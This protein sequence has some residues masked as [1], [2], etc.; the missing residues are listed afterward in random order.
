M[1]ESIQKEINE[2][3]RTEHRRDHMFKQC[4]SNVGNRWLKKTLEW[5]YV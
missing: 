2:E 1:N 5:I 3:C 4:M